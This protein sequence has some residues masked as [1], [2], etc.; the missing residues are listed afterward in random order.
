MKYTVVWVL[1]ALME[2]ATIWTDAEDRAAVAA[3]SDEI[4]RRS[5]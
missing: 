4:D 3:A 2:L 1:A 5:Q